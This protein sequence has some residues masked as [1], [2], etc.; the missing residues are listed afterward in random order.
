MHNLILILRFIRADAVSI[1]FFANILMCLYRF[2][3]QLAFLHHNIFNKM[4][5][6]SCGAV[7]RFPVI[8]FA[9]TLGSDATTAKKAY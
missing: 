1:D 9:F 5:R 6:Q 4:M 8:S 7:K 2:D 3:L